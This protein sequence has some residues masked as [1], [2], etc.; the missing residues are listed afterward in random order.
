MT[1]TGIYPKLVRYEYTAASFS[2]FY[3]RKTHFTAYLAASV[4]KCYINIEQ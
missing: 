2:N 1:K 3:G 4:Y